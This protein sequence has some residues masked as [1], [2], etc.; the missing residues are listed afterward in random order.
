MRTVERLEIMLQQAESATDEM[1][2]RL[3]EDY[4]KEL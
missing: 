3:M 1:K 4:N 2:G